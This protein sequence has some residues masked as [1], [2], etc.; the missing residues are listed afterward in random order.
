VNVD[1]FPSL[2]ALRVFAAC[3]RT[4][5]FARAAE[6]FGISPGAVTQHIRTVEKWVDAPL[7]R[8][9]GRSVVPTEAAEA[10]LPVLLEGFHRLAEGA[11]TLLSFGSATQIISVSA[12]PA[13]ASK[14]LL[15]RLPRFRDQHPE[16]DLWVQ[17]DPH[18]QSPDRRAPDVVISYGLEI[19]DGFVGEPLT[20]DSVVVVASPDF[21]RRHGPFDA[22]EKIASAPLLHYDSR[23]TDQ[24]FPTW[25][26]WFRAQGLDLPDLTKGTRFDHPG[27]LVEY[28]IAGQGIALAKRMVAITDVEAGRLEILS[29]FGVPVA[30]SYWLSHMRGRTMR[31]ASS[32]FWN[33]V[34]EEV[35]SVGDGP[36]AL[37]V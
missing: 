9:T 8:R 20:R 32:I 25:Q 27:L 34:K 26:R 29:G 37:A 35:R 3:T 17:I 12:P 31:A 5:S 4:R 28:A 19:G 33:W 22:P 18:H 36:R 30:S 13:F 16:I 21:V 6:E 2:T 14:W 11:D 10:A 24:T 23:H 7:F 1:R 15:P